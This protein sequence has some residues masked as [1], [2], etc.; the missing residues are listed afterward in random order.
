MI[1]ERFARQP[2]RA[3]FSVGKGLFQISLLSFP[4]SAFKNFASSGDSFRVFGV[5]IRK[6]ACWKRL[7]AFRY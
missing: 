7:F 5:F 6:Y 1:V 2:G 3:I 4:M